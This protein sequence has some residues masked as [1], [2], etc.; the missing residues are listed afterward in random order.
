[1]AVL[2]A[3]A[4]LGQRL[5]HV[6]GDWRQA[7]PTPQAVTVVQEGTLKPA[8]PAQKPREAPRPQPAAEP[9]AETALASAAAAPVA[10]ASEP[11]GSDRPPEQPAAPAQA[12]APA[13]ADP[14]G[15]TPTPSP[16]AASAVDPWPPSTRIRYTLRGNFRGEFSG[17]AQVL[18]LREGQQYRVELDVVIGPR[19]APVMSRRVVSE[20]R[21]TE[22]GL[23]PL[24][25]DEVTRVIFT[26]ARRVSMTF[27]PGG[28]GQEGS[29]LLSDGKRRPAPSGTQDSASQFVQLAWLFGTRAVPP[30]MGDKVSFPLALSRRSDIWSYE[31]GEAVTLQ[32]PAGPVQALHAK[33]QRELD[34][35]RRELLAEV[36]FAPSLQ[37]LPVRMQ[38]SVD[39][40]SYALMVMDGLPELVRAGSPGADRLRA[41]LPSVAASGAPPANTAPPEPKP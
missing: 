32:T 13:P 37:Y 23:V 21:L 39:A 10:A 2:L 27:E 22:Q 1:M 38:V 3:H 33:P 28:P 20:G 4:W 24:R 30:Q 15:P 5:S 11:V 19:A 26:R 34:P 14:A 8:E 16:P 40:D 17:S 41:S 29:V 25:Y 12:T 31:V 35:L 18:W 6:L 36:W 9:A 7:P